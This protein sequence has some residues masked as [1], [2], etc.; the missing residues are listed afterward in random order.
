MSDRLGELYPA[1]PRHCRPK[2]PIPSQ[3]C[4][5]ALVPPLSRCHSRCQHYSTMSG[6]QYPPRGPGPL[7]LPFPY[8]NLVR[9]HCCIA[10]TEPRVM[11]MNSAFEVLHNLNQPRAW[12]DKM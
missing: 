3:H 9:L 4:H 1:Y 7:A 2:P 12:T 5:P 6:R 10:D 8:N 11:P